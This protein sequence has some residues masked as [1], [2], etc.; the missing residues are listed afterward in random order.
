MNRKPVSLAATLLLTTCVLPGEPSDAER[1]TFELDFEQPYRVPLAGAVQPPIQIAADGRVL[2]APS[3][4]LESLD[5]SLVRVD[6]TGHELQGIARGT[7]TV[8][9]IYTTA[10][11]APDTTFAVQVVVS[12]V[13]VLSPQATLTRLGDTVRLAA[14]AFDAN[15]APVSNVP[16]TWT[17]ADPGVVSVSPVGLVT[18][19][20]DG[21]AMVAAEVD[22]V[23]DSAAVTVVQAAA[24]VRIAPELDTLRTVG[25][26]A[27]FLAVAFD[28]TG[29]VLRTAKPRWSS[30]DETVA[31]VDSTG[32]ATADSAGTARIIARVGTAADTATL[33]VA[34]VA[35]LLVVRPG[36]DTLTAIADTARI[37]A[38]AFDSLN[39]PIPNP[40][41]SWVTSDPA[42]ATVDPAGLVQAAKN[43][44]VLVTAASG[45]QSAFATVVVRQEVVAARIAEENVTL[46]GAGA[47][48]RLSGAGLDRNGFVVP[49]AALTWRSGSACVATVAAGLVTARGSGETAVTAT[50]LNGGRSDTAVVTVTRAPGSQ[51]AV[52]FDGHGIYVLCDPGDYP[53]IL[54][55]RVG[56][57]AWS[58][59]GASI[60]FVRRDYDGSSCQRI[61]I[62]R[63]DGSDARRITD[64]CDGAPAWSPDGTRIAFSRDGALYIAGVDGSNV[65]KLGSDGGHPTWSPDGTR[66]AFTSVASQLAV[67]NA[68]GTGFRLISDPVTAYRVIH[69]AWSPDGS[70]LA[71][72][73]GENLLL[74]NSDGS[75]QRVLV[76]GGQTWGNGWLL[77]EVR[78]WEPAWS[79]DGAQIVF[80]SRSYIQNP[81][82][83]N[84]YSSLSWGLFFVNRDGTGLRMIATGEEP[85][86]PTWRR[87]PEP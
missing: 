31:R 84:P 49:D 18:A 68:D 26:S 47:T 14:S 77:S 60:A 46:T 59:D 12:R 29:A 73:D 64:G 51:I 39:F 61:Y 79:P 1:V 55:P 48:V 85:H 8:R 54:S 44:V 67:I 40:S 76:R 17:S 35:R 25:R 7:A 30:S 50:P 87:I 15:D 82:P 56:D 38:L 43:G 32:L 24:Q 83:E 28:D 41:L 19:R 52:Q 27:Q 20:N 42:V 4:R 71:F 21:E 9:V 10:T 22:G 2:Q 62:A 16:F 13:A 63:T 72:D 33:V 34:Q 86:S 45:G 75:G 11:G 36:F 70:Q 37:A 65:R 57:P 6:Q 69:P 81:D 78:N 53:L 3:Y 74:I 23:S 58:P 5:P 80:G 66:L